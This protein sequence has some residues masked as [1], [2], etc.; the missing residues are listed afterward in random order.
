MVGTLDALYSSLDKVDAETTVEAQETFDLVAGL[1]GAIATI[2]ENVAA[3][4]DLVMDPL[5]INA[6]GVDS[7][8]AAAEAQGVSMDTFGAM[9]SRFDGTIGAIAYLLLIL[10]YI[11]CV[12]VLG[13]INR[14]IGGGW[15]MF[16]ASW[17]M[18]I[19]YSVAVFFYQAATFARHPLSSSAWM[20]GLSLILLSVIVIMRMVGDRQGQPSTISVAE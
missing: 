6:A 15:A 4:G 20:G 9:V 14:E 1:S 2:P 13:A 12:A 10:L 7:K 3:L 8:E 17:T 19:G 5:G 18:G 11:P 16:T